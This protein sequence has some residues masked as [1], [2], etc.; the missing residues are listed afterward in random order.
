MRIAASLSIVLLTLLSGTVRAA[1]VPT[2]LTGSEPE[3]VALY[4]FNE[5]SGND[6]VI[7]AGALQD[8]SANNLDGTHATTRVYTNSLSGF[9]EEMRIS[10]SDIR[11][12]GGSLTSSFFQGDFTIEAWIKVDGLTKT[13]GNVGQV[14]TTTQRFFNSRSSSIGWIFQLA[15]DGTANKLQ[16]HNGSAFSDAITGFTLPTSGWTHWA[17][18]FTNTNPGSTDSAYSV[19]FYVTDPSV[20]TEPNLIGTFNLNPTASTTSLAAIALAFTGDA[21]F[22]FAPNIDS[23]RIDDVRVSNVALTTFAALGQTTSIPEPATLG[24]LALGGLGLAG[25]ARRRRH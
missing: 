21:T 6:V 3:T 23:V 11:L 22:S 20:D 8:A 9:G 4:N 12:P 18:V 5:F 10:T 13:T 17:M 19:Q 24:L 16:V 14:I 2:A 15:T 1:L 7:S 25:A